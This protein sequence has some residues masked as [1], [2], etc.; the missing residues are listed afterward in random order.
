MRI[1]LI[2]AALLASACAPKPEPFTIQAC[3]DG[4]QLAQF[5]DAC[6]GPR[7]AEGAEPTDSQYNA[8][9]CSTLQLRVGQYC[10]D[11]ATTPVEATA[12]P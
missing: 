6:L 7:P 9:L 10:D 8:E 2:L 12:N 11:P 3:I 5:R 1:I 4:A